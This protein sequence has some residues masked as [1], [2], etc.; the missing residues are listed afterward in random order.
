MVWLGRLPILRQNEQTLFDFREVKKTIHVE[1][2]PKIVQIEL[3]IAW[4]SQ[5]GVT[6]IELPHA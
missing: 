3:I 5:R 4:C 1:C 6:K 2:N